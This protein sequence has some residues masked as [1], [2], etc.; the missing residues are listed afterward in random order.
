MKFFAYTL[1]KKNLYCSRFLHKG[2]V[3]KNTDPSRGMAANKAYP[4]KLTKQFRK[5]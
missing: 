3:I 2:S 1:K 4:R 5:C